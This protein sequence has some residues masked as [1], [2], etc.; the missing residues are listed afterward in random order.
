M[1]SPQIIS[2]IASAGPIV[3]VPRLVGRE[4]L[5]SAAS[6]CVR[7]FNRADGS[8]LKSR[9]GTAFMVERGKDRYF[10]T[11]RHLLDYNYNPREASDVIYSAAIASVA[12][13]GYTPQTFG[14]EPWTYSQETPRVIFHP[15]DS[16]DLAVI[17]VPDEPPTSSDSWKIPNVDC[18]MRWIPIN[19][20]LDWLA[21]GPDLQ[22]L[23]PGDQIFIAGY[24]SHE[25]VQ[26][27]RPLIVSGIVASDPQYPAMFGPT[28]LRDAV[29]CHSFSWGGM[30]GAPVFGFSAEMEKVRIV[31]IN[32]GHI[33]SNDVS[34]GVISH[35]VRSSALIELLEHLD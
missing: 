26:S 18:G 11:N 7:F 5:Y 23:T 1:D 27:E 28:R 33:E 25:G 13:R 4:H 35:F 2:G 15:E 12:I 34:G 29:F 21:S 20:G 32:G 17:A 14:T 31:G 19:F 24:P 10:V 30:S 6:I 22:L 3:Y 16:T 8:N 9:Y